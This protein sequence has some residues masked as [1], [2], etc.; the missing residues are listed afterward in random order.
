L[1]KNGKKAKPV[2]LLSLRVSMLSDAGKTDAADF[3]SA[4]GERSRR[5]VSRGNILQVR[6]ERDQT[7][8]RQ[9]IDGSGRL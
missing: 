1:K 5:P 8:T 7:V 3:M 6:R 2:A 4:C 9:G